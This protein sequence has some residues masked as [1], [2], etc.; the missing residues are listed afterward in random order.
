VWQIAAA[1]FADDDGLD[2]L[3]F[4]TAVTATDTGG[5]TNDLYI[6]P[7]T[8][9]MTVAGSPGAEEYVIFQV[10]R[11]PANGSDT[12]AIDARLHGVKLHYT[13]SSATDD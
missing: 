1:A 4:G 7:E 11:V 3:A 2:A 8:S 13:T 10:A 6:S 12:M 5:T 9:A